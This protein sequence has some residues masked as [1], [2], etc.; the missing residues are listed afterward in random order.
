M[1]GKKISICFL[2]LLT[3]T[4]ICLPFSFAEMNKNEIKIAIDLPSPDLLELINS[5]QEERPDYKIELLRYDTEESLNQ[6][7]IDLIR[8]NVP[9]VLAFFNRTSFLNSNSNVLY[10]LNSI[11]Q[12]CTLDSIIP[13]LLHSVTEKGILQWIP[14]DFAVQTFIAPNSLV[15][16]PGISIT[17]VQEIA[18]NN[19]MQLFCGALGREAL[20]DWISHLSIRGFIDEAFLECHFNSPEYVSL[21]EYVNQISNEMN[22][23]AYNDAFLLQTEY[24]QNF[25]RLSAI[26]TFTN[27]NYSFVGC[28]SLPFINSNGSIFDID[29]AFAIPLQ[30]KN[31]LGASEFIDY[32]ISNGRQSIIQTYFP[33]NKSVLKLN[34][35]SAL[36]DGIDFYGTNY[37]ITSDDISKF[38]ALISNTSFEYDQY[39]AIL[40]IVKLEADKFFHG[41]CNA[42]TAAM[43][44]QRKVLLYLAEIN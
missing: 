11:L 40:S 32:A 12:Q 37:K 34:A 18:A 30:S 19:G 21:L 15:S 24:L 31:S 9:D 13:S 25:I 28:P 14:F 6:L 41:Q 8:G 42:E 5:F 23:A 29:L 33:A 16:S 27:Q 39:G 26:S 20:W 22:G 36:N 2:I 10:D 17:D 3:F 1:T 7:K 43:N 38:N 35:E 4:S 44:T